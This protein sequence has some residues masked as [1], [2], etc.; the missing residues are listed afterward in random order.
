MPAASAVRGVAE[1][2]KQVSQHRFG[3]V[4]ASEKEDADDPEDAHQAVTQF[5]Q[6]IHQRRAAGLDLVNG[7]FGRRAR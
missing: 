2:L 1:R 5:Q 4:P 6:V 7:G 3:D